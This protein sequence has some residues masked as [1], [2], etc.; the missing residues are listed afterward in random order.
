[1]ILELQELI[2]R[3]LPTRP[4]Q[5]RLS[6]VAVHHGKLVF[7]AFRQGA[8]EPEFVV[9]VSSEKEV[10][11]LHDVLTRL[12]QTIPRLTAQ[13]L[14]IG[15]LSDGRF[16]QIQSAFPGLPW[17]SLAG[18]LH[19]DD[20]RRVYARALDVL[21]ALHAAIDA[22]PAWH[23]QISP[24]AELRRQLD[25][26][27]QYD[28]SLSAGALRFAESCIQ[29]LAELGEIFC[30]WQHGDFCANNLMVAGPDVRI[31]DFDEFG[32]TAMPLHDQFGLALSVHE[33]SPADGTGRPL[34][35]EVRT[36]TAAALGRRPALAGYVR[37][38]L[39]H[40]LLW[41]VNLC[42]DHPGR[43]ERM[44]AVLKQLEAFA[45]AP[46]EYVPPSVG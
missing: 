40:H 46:G 28:V 24:S 43:A 3:L 5:G 17:V 18:S 33:L 6:F 22:I 32:L 35:E 21:R 2:Q 26:C 11:R 45:A 7:L 39:V 36:C 10:R 30:H 4:V 9:T 42:H 27:T 16:V 34:A 37:G 25:L 31:F 19:R 41:H 44:K 23:T 29:H 1:M 13:S 15:R 12:Y 8:R 38:L 20:R 14:A